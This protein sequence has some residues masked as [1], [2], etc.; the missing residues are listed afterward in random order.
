MLR[1]CATAALANR[2]R[3]RRNF[4]LLSVVLRYT[5]Q[6]P[7]LVSEH[8]VAEPGCHSASASFPNTMRVLSILIQEEC[9]YVAKTNHSRSSDRPDG[10]TGRVSFCSVK[11]EFDTWNNSPVRLW[12]SRSRIPGTRHSANPC[13][14]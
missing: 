9:N 3:F 14:L 11:C 6:A 10:P 2:E 4:G 12:A 1:W 8:S 5:A 7:S 13:L